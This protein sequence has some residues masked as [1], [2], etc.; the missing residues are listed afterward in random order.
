[1]YMIFLWLRIVT[2]LRNFALY[3]LEHRI[4]LCVSFVNEYDT[5]QPY[6]FKVA[7]TS[8]QSF[9]KIMKRY[10]IFSLQINYYQIDQRHK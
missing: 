5:W 6:K 7:Y 4:F 2:Y 1:M 10:P 9:E 8:G 3:N